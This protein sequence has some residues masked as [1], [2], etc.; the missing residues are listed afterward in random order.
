MSVDPGIDPTPSERAVGYFAGVVAWVFGS[1]VV[2]LW[3][4]VG[5]IDG[6]LPTSADV[7]ADALPVLA[8][9]GGVA[10]AVTTRWH[11]LGTILAAAAVALWIVAFV[12]AVGTR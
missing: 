10:M 1:I 12:I 4:L 11:R 3:V 2:W 8:I 7:S 5:H 9:L 6:G